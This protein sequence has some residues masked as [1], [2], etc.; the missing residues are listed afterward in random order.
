MNKLQKRLLAIQLIV[1]MAFTAPGIP[2]V[3]A[4]PNDTAPESDL[5]EHHP[6]HTADCGYKEVIEAHVC[7]HE[8]TEDCY[9]SEDHCIHKHTEEC[10]SEED[11]DLFET[12]TPSDLE[13]IE[14][15]HICSEDSG[16][17]VRQLNCQHEHDDLCGY[18]EGEEEI[19][20]SFVCEICDSQDV[21]DLA[22]AS[23]AEMM[24]EVEMQPLPA[25]AADE[26]PEEQFE[27]TP[28]T[29][30]WFDLSGISM[31]GNVNKGDIIT[32]YESI[33]GIKAVPDTSFHWVPF[34]YTGTIHAYV[35]NRNSEGSAESSGQA[36]ASEDDGAEYGYAYDHSLFISDYNLTTRVSWDGLKAKGLVY[37][38]EYTSGGVE[39][40]LRIPSV[41]SVLYNPLKDQA[42][43]KDAIRGKP[44]NNEWDAI[45][46]KE[47]SN[48]DENG[49]IKNVLKLSSYGQDTSS[50]DESRR[51][52]RG[53]SYGRFLQSISTNANSSGNCYRPVLEILQAE[54]LRMDG[55]QTV[56]L[57]LNGGTVGDVSGTIN[58]AVKSE[59]SFTAPAKEG[60]I[61]PEG[62]PELK[63]ED[64][65]GNF[66]Q[67]GQNV[68]ADVTKLTAYWY[69][70]EPLKEPFNL[71]PG[72]TYWFDLSQE[73]IPGK[74]NDNIAH[75]APVQDPTLHWIPFTYTGAIRAYVLN[76]KSAGL[77]NAS[78]KAS[79]AAESGST[80]GYTYDHCLFIADNPVTNS[81]S[82]DS[83]NKKNMIF[84]ADYSKGGVDY[85]IRVP[86]VGSKYQYSDTSSTA[87]P[88]GA[89]KNN[90]WDSILDKNA[91]YIKNTGKDLDSWGQDT[92]SDPD[93]T[94]Y[95]VLRDNHFA[96]G[97]FRVKT[98]MGY[99]YCGFRPVLEIKNADTLDAD[100]LKTVEIHLNGG[101]IGD[102][103]EN[104]SIVVKSRNV[105]QA[106]S[107]EGIT[108]PSEYQTG[109]KLQWCISE[110]GGLTYN[111]GEN[112]QSHVTNLYAQWVP[113]SYRVTLDAA[114]GTIAPEKRISSYVYGKEVSLPTAD[115]MQKTGYTFAGW[116]TDPEF[117]GSAVDK[118][119]D[120]DYG[121]K[122][123]Y[124]KWAANTYTVTLDTGG[125]QIADGHE[126]T[127][128]AYGTGVTLPSAD[129]I[130]KRGH[131]FAGWYRNRTFSGNPVTQIGADEMENKTFYAKWEVNTYAVTLYAENGTIA[132]GKE[133]T[134]Y[135]YGTG[136]LL[137]S[138]NE[139]SRTDYTFAGW[140]T[141]RD[142]S[143]SAVTEIKPD[144]VG[145]KTFYA[146]W[147]RNA[148][149]VLPG[150]TVRYIVEH[151]KK[152][153]GGY[154][155]A[156]TEFF[157]GKIGTEVAAL[158]KVYEGYRC[159][160]NAQGTVG[161]GTLKEIDSADDIVVL[162]LYYD[163][164]L[165][166]ITIKETDCGR[167]FASLDTAAV[168][169]EITLTSIADTGYRLA[170]WE[171]I[172]GSVTVVDNKF[173]MPEDSVTVKPIFEKIPGN[174]SG[175]SGIDRADSGSENSAVSR[176]IVRDKVK[177]MINSSQGII[178]GANNCTEYDG[179]SHW[180]LDE[181]GWWLR[182]ADGTYPKAGKTDQSEEAYAWEFV[183]GRWWAFDENGYIKTGW[184]KDK[185]YHAWFYVDPLTGMYSNQRTPDGYYVG[186]NG[187]WNCKVSRDFSGKL[188]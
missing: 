141:D 176:D 12:A 88:D 145:D 2:I 93:D 104:V 23:D 106:P 67:P 89:P 156:D 63:W 74:V 1:V 154:T 21:V 118:I 124:A 162:K 107:G 56:K 160:P 179:Y 101:K 70:E 31:P 142:F 48:D 29:T 95:R 186:E 109:Y 76:A 20:C 18:K 13:P 17:V 57:D 102:V 81:V 151:Y 139:I 44:V 60:L 10:Y 111:P 113:A 82:W 119:T 65:Q 133:V 6:E 147:L 166:N 123:Y 188:W 87:K 53:D 49:Y 64:E 59:K 11:E 36:S 54:E 157:A 125:G 148:V 97:F 41:G 180:M 52:I 187:A 146:R 155:L 163:Q 47:K 129:E 150:D 108:A 77:S 161:K 38:K 75:G 66:Y 32:G 79:Q 131:T 45:M 168:G 153:D 112:V 183:N 149:P 39:Y 103:E 144:D 50:A 71:I 78:D 92:Y 91:E 169:T 182:F 132:S 110:T 167:A 170:G 105:F 174:G 171:I 122:T 90:E 126:V 69:A 72:K 175:S 4:S 158:P 120:A 137:P 152:A 51:I 8:H 68:L 99:W 83:L 100:S 40:S 26:T 24:T 134:G 127:E 22:T 61:C 30:Y 117:H 14:C 177:G 140:Y 94:A 114:E 181:H 128:Y 58:I 143:G 138:A 3:Y 96:R 35:L 164:V 33:T 28:G 25:A 27:L 9:V 16:C 165:Y 184:L 73:D 19:P 159:N 98:D 7:G 172:H 121:D 85:T 37:G 80:Y 116:Y 115:D 173:I 62:K 178:T 86:S 15:S 185:K 135:T 42:L 84:G 55:L 46:N 34:T 130:S 136:A 43:D 5:C